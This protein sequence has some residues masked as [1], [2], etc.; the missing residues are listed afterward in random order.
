[1][2][3]HIVAQPVDRLAEL[4]A[5]PIAFVADRVLEAGAR[6]DALTDPV[7]VERPLER[8]FVKDYDALPDE[9]PATWSRRYDTAHWCL[10]AAVGPDGAWIGGAVIARD[11]PGVTML[12]GRNDLAVLWDLR[13]APGLRRRGVG[14]ALFEAALRWSVRHGCRELKVETQNINVAACRFYAAQGCRLLEVDADAYPDLPG[15]T[16]FIWRRELRALRPLRR[17]DATPLAEAFAAIGWHKPAETFLRYVA[18]E[19]A[20]ARSCWVAEEFGDLA[21]YVTVRWPAPGITEPAAIEDLNVLPS[22]RNRGVGTA[23]LDQAEASVARRADVVQIAVGL[24]GGYGAAQRLYV[25]RGY[26]PDGRGASIAGR[27]VAEG[28][29]VALDDALVITMRKA[30]ERQA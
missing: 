25:Q 10:L 11:T 7:L 9:G 19:E 24:H 4:A 27:P 23:L 17:D 29:A 20:G 22:F 28:A 16:R 8:P 13:V 18:E 12:E 3:F 15:E 2:D 14:R 1:M 21:G 26:V 30:L 6:H 5:I